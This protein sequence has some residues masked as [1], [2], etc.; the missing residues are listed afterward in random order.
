MKK[1]R[2]GLR[3]TTEYRLWINIK[4]RC[5][6][7]KNK[8]WG[9]Y[10]GRGITVCNRW[11]N[12]AV[13]FISDMGLRP[14]PNHQLDR[15]DNDKGYSPE[16]CHWVL[17]IPQ[18]QNT[19]LAKRWM[20]Y[21]KWFNSLSEAANFHSTTPSRIK[22]WCEGRSDGGYIYPPKANCTSVKAYDQ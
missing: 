22:A 3:F 16:N 15:I 9:Y 11:V 10:G 2:H 19:R 12:S 18:M 4:Q 6:N 1:V 8:S 17:K 5:Y 7:P 20:V 14:S 13:N 21:G